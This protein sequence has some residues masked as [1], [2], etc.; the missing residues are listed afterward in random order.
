MFLRPNHR[1]KDGKEHVYWSLVEAL[2][3]CPIVRAGNGPAMGGTVFRFPGKTG[4]KSARLRVPNPSR[5]AP[6]AYRQLPQ[7]AKQWNP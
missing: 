4:K 6:P 5:V 1:H 3:H 2:L 7:K